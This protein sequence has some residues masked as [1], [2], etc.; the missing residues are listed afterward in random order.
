LHILYSSDDTMVQ[1]ALTDCGPLIRAMLNEKHQGD[2]GHPGG[3]GR[4]RGVVIT[5]YH[6]LSR[7]RATLWQNAEQGEWRSAS[8]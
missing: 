7:H 3:V 6:D 2:E 1:I 8:P 4:R 5:E